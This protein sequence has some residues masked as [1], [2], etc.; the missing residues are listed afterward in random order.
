M[1]PASIGLADLLLVLCDVCEALEEMHRLG[2]VHK[3]VKTK[4]ILVKYDSELNRWVG[5]LGDFDLSQT[6]GFNEKKNG[7]CYWSL[8]AQQGFVSYECDGYG[9]V[10]ALGEIFFGRDYQRYMNDRTMILALNFD[11]LLMRHMKN[12]AIKNLTGIP[13]TIY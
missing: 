9:V 12:Y 10:S 7:Y 6:V 2:F 1:H 3:D 8:C 11:I 13:Y 5:K 4:N